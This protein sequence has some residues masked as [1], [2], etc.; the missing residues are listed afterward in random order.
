MV[1]LIGL[2]DAPVAN[3]ALANL[4]IRVCTRSSHAHKTRKRFWHVRWI[5]KRLSLSHWDTRTLLV[6]SIHKLCCHE[7]RSRKRS[8]LRTQ[9]SRTFL[10]RTQVSLRPVTL[11]EHANAHV[12]IKTH[13]RSSHAH[14]VGER[15]GHKN[16]IHRG[17][18]LLHLVSPSLMA[19]SQYSQTLLSRTKDSQGSGQAHRTSKRLCH[20]YSTCKRSVMHTGPTI[21]PLTYKELANA[22]VAHSGLANARSRAQNSRTPTLRTLDFLTLLSPTL[23]DAVVM[24]RHWCFSCRS[25]DHRTRKRWCHEHRL[26]TRSVT[27][28]GVP[29]RSRYNCRT[30]KCS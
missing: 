5:P 19:Q 23:T 17:C 22:P 9:D 13:Q 18:C 4:R 10:S 3:P 29:N 30:Q 7:L 14:R 27:L 2:A 8:C 15:R 6:M 25:H 21:A 1:T 16:G 11:S 26:C 12:T 20:P 24:H 28:T